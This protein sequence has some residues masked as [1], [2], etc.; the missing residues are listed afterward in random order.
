MLGGS[1]SFVS[2][3]FESGFVVGGVL[4]VLLICSVICWA[5][6]FYK[7]GVIRRA[8][9]ESRE[10]MD[11]FWDSTSFRAVQDQIGHLANS[12]LAEV[13]RAGY[14]E[15]KRGNEADT[16]DAEADAGDVAIRMGSAESVERSL[17]R[18]SDTEAARLD[19]LLIF[20]AT[21]ASAAPFIGLF[22]TVWGIME[23]FRQIGATGTA[24]LAVVAPGISEA[25]IATATGLAAAIPAVVAYN[26]F[27]NSITILSTE[28]ESFITEF[29]NIIGP[30]SGDRK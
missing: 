1:Q 3:A 14:L 25:L 11:I 12:P 8:T 10:F 19:R 26:F 20:L 7:Y 6:I 27:R 9:R 24:N 21:V 2:M 15:W 4:V 22:G 30:T 13:F 18:A 16:G 29:L 23:S 5:V 28:M 17:R